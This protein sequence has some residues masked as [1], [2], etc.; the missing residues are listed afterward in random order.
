MD[1]GSFQAVVYQNPV[2]Y[3]DNGV[4]KDIDNTLVDEGS[5]VTNKD[6]DFKIKFAKKS[7]DSKLVTIQEDKY[8]IAWG[9]ARDKKVAED[10]VNKMNAVDNVVE[11]GKIA[12][13]IS[14]EEKKKAVP[15]TSSTVD[16]ENIYNNVDL[17]YKLESDTVKENIIINKK[18]DSPVF[19]FALQLKNVVPKLNDDK[20]ITFYDEKDSSKSIYKIDA[21]YMYDAKNHTSNK[22]NVK[23]LKNN[24][25]YVIQ[26]IPDSS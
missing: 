4:W 17:Q 20:T 12:V 24:N 18:I 10:A 21:P 5:D 3:L 9:I 26:V 2:H 1:D 11:N 16:Y 8:E 19:E 23:L 22:I 25:Q 15:N 14:D 6:N 7:N 13:G